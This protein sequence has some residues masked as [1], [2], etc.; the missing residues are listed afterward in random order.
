MLTLEFSG[1][2]V[3]VAMGFQNATLRRA[4]MPRIFVGCFFL[5]PPPPFFICEVFFC[6][7]FLKCEAH[8]GLFCS[9][10]PFPAAPSHSLSKSKLPLKC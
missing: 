1:C 2:N 9:T 4:E 8:A 6:I 5:P 10:G 7:S 3:I